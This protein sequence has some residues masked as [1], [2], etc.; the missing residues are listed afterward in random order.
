[1]QTGQALLRQLIV[2]R[3]L[4]RCM[5]AYRVIR[6]SGGSHEGKAYEEGSVSCNSLNLI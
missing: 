3:A 4:S 6:R 2:S 5:Q 1:M